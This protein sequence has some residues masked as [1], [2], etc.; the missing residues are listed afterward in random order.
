[1]SENRSTTGV[2]V[3]YAL[4]VLEVRGRAAEVLAAVGSAKL[5]QVALFRATKWAE[6]STYTYLDDRRIAD[7]DWV[8]AAEWLR[9][10]W[11]LPA[12]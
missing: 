5:R 11:T 6:A 10:G 1:M 8:R 12:T 9:I 4:T 2:E 7:I 3:A